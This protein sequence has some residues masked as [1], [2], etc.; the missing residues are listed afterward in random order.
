[1]QNSTMAYGILPIERGTW[2]A[3]SSYQ[4]GES[5]VR[6]IRNQPNLVQTR[7]QIHHHKGQAPTPGGRTQ[8]MT[9]QA[10]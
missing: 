10:S 7:R 8:M 5:E 4:Q 3:V 9:R 2:L 1:M 6:D